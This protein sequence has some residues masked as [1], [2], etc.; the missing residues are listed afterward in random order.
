MYTRSWTRTFTSSCLIVL[1]LGFKTPQIDA[2]AR[3]TASPMPSG[4]G[5]DLLTAACTQCHGTRTIAMMQEGSTEWKVLVYDMILRGAQLDAKEAETLIQYLSKHRDMPATPASTAATAPAAAPAAAPSTAAAAAAT[6]VMPDGPG[7]ELVERKCNACHDL[8]PQLF[9]RSPDE[10]EQVV[11]SMMNKG[12]RGTPQEI[13]TIKAYLIE[14][15]G[16]K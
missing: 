5:R 6:P 11:Q 8:E 7:K 9:K 10:W 13:A 16:Q 2:Q 14:H 15:W 12:L 1:V 4:E 3:G